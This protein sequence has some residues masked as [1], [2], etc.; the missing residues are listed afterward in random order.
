MAIST[1]LEYEK[2]ENLF[3]DPL[4]P[5]LG[6]HRAS[7]D[8]SQDELLKRMRTWTLEEIANSYLASGGFW[9]YEPLIAVRDQLYGKTCL[10]VVEGNR[11]LAALKYLQQ[12]I[13]GEPIS[14]KWAEMIQEAKVPDGLFEQVPY[15]LVSTRAEVKAFLGFRHVTGIKQWDAD[16][17]AA[18]IAKL[19]DDDGMSYSEV[20]RR[21]GST[22]PTV[23]QNYIA[24]RLLLQA[25]ST[26][27]EFEPERADTRFAVLYMTLR[28]VGARE[29]LHVNINAKPEQS[30][31]PVPQEYLE[32]L[33]YFVQWLFGTHD[34]PQ[35]VTDTRQV[36]DFATILQNEDAVSYLKT[37]QEPKLDI[38]Y[39]IAGGDEN[40]IIHYVR[41]AAQ[42]IELALMRAHSFKN[43]EELQKAVH[44]LGD[45]VIQ[46]L[47][48]FPDIKR[49]VLAGG[50]HQ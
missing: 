7:L 45:D 47:S 34:I 26:I 32:N 38:A 43:S 1:K 29:Y 18:F 13:N 22:E 23:R 15:I 33:R 35:L 31:D 11:R 17:K 4:N 28:T 40:V 41:D 39:R 36:E 49:A 2:V 6:R 21:I 27:E 5:R 12:A 14:R 37:S 50:E 48:V 8:T 16:E 20:A 42:N 25:E 10:I 24:Y 44:R 46:L 3:L 19:I 30:R 9:T